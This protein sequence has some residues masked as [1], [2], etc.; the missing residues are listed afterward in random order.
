MKHLLTLPKLCVVLF[1]GL[2]SFSFVSSISG[3]NQSFVQISTVKNGADQYKLVYMQRGASGKRIKAKYFAANDPYNNTTVPNRYRNWKSSG[4]Q[5]ICATSGTYMDN[6]TASRA[7][8]VGLTIDNGVVVN[9]S[10]A[11]FDGLVIVYATGGVVATNLEDK[12][13]TVQGGS[14]SGIPLDIR[15]NAYHREQFIKWCED[16]EATV[17]QTHMLAYKN[18]LK[19]SSYNSSKDSR[20][21]RFL[22]VGTDENGQV[23]HCIIHSPQY[24]T[25]YEGS[26]RA[27]SFMNDFKD[28]NVIFMVNLDTGA[29]DFFDLYNSDGTLNNTI[30]GQKSVNDTRNMLVYYYE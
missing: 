24:T 18:Q 13:L 5:I 20:E 11:N 6:L 15:G 3:Y 19:I 9:R 1:L 17:F 22:V 25:L 30:T 29:Q 14:I 7:T 12:N 2:I 27:L 10:L 23:V 21:R 8:P 4:K 28:M 16:N 26:K